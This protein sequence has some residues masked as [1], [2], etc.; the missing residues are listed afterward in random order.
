[1][2]DAKHG[3]KKPDIMLIDQ[4][5]RGGISYQIVLSKADRVN[6]HEGTIQKLFED[7]RNLV[8]RDVSGVSGLGEI[9]ALSAKPHT[10]GPKFGL[11]NLR[12]AIM[13]ACSVH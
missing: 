13:V 5:G 4:L 1:M 10:N 9:L 8:N 2:I 12:W 11:D 6:S 3:P 7:M